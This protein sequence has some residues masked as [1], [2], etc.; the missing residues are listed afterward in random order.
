M[1]QHVMSGGRDS[2][3]EWH[4]RRL[5][6][7]LFEAKANDMVGTRG[8]TSGR[9]LHW[10]WILATEPGNGLKDIS[11]EQWMYLADNVTLLNRTIVTKL[12]V[13]LAEISEQF[14]RRP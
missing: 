14:V 6:P 7:H 9:T 13:R 11:M 1:I 4:M 3:R 2:V 8:S 12:G 10:T 5:G